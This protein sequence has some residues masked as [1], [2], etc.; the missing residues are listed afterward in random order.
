MK[1]IY[2]P[3]PYL[4]DRKVMSKTEWAK[5]HDKNGF[6][7]LRVG[8]QIVAVVWGETP[9]EQTATS[10]V[11]ASAP[12]LVQTLLRLTDKEQSLLGR[13]VQQPKHPYFAQA[14]L[15][16]ELARHSVLDATGKEIQSC[17]SP[18]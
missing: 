14:C 6:D 1:T 4:A 12:R 16:Y 11:L 8:D 7:I 13:L 15:D 2:H 9:L 17:I 5:L 3:G 10:Q 18:N